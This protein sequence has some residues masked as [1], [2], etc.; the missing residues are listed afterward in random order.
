[1]GREGRPA[2]RKLDSYSVWFPGAGERPV[3]FPIEKAEAEK[4]FDILIAYSFF[5]GLVLIF[6]WGVP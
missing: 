5:I 2:F 4:E 6:I 1:M 3:Y